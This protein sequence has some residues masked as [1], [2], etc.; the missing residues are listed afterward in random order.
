MMGKQ[1]RILV[2]Q[3]HQDALDSQ[4]MCPS[5]TLWMH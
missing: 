5:W 2:Q 1:Y 3:I 4:K